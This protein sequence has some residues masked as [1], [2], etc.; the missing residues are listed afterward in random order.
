MHVSELDVARVDNPEALFQVPGPAREARPARRLVHVLRRRR[1]NWSKSGHVVNLYVSRYR[2][3][4]LAGPAGRVASRPRDAGR[5]AAGPTRAVGP[6]AADGA[7]DR[8]EAG[9]VRCGRG[10]RRRG[11][12][13]L[14]RLDSAC[15]RG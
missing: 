7:M 15:G 11:G 10:G 8:D 13:W 5:E 6:T 9:S 2:S 3:P 1:D 4:A 12:A 14:R